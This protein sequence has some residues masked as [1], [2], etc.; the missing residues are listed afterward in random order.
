MIYHVCK[1]T[2]DIMCVMSESYQNCSTDTHKLLKIFALNEVHRSQMYWKLDLNTYK[3]L[4]LRMNK[5]FIISR[6]HFDIILR[7]PPFKTLII[8]RW[9]CRPNKDNY[10]HKKDS[11]RIYPE[12]ILI[13]RNK[14]LNYFMK[15]HKKEQVRTYP[16][17]SG[18]GKR[19]NPI[20]RFVSKIYSK[21]IWWN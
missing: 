7:L 15:K 20:F 11:K 21:F 12:N 19:L 17:L 3:W 6:I 4:V 18:H 5:V 9:N 8:R 16:W 13:I 14:K 2:L 1:C 10:V